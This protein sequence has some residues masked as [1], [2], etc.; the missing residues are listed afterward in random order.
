M[1]GNTLHVSTPK[2]V[3]YLLRVEFQIIPS[4]SSLINASFFFLPQCDI[5]QPDVMRIAPAPLYNS[6]KD[7][8]H[9]I[10]TLQEVFAFCKSEG[11]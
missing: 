11:A 9:F 8:Y 1:D 6:F 5:R 2:Y 10:K 3:G 4:W 7:V